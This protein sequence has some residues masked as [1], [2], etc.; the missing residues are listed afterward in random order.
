MWLNKNIHVLRW[1]ILATFLIY[2]PEKILDADRSVHSFSLYRVE[3][4]SSIFWGNEN[5]DAMTH[6]CTHLDAHTYTHAYTHKY[7]M[8][9]SEKW[10]T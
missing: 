5:Y 2:F 7:K 8:N 1:I 3:K 9:I 6:T 4:R 10:K